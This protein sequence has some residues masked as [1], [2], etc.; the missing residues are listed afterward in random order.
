MNYLSNSAIDTKQLAVSIAKKVTGGT[1]IALNGDLGTGKTTFTQGFA[2][3]LGV[4][5]T[6]ISPTFKLVSEYEG[7]KLWLFHIDAY[8]MNGSQDFLNI[9]GEK[10]LVPLNG[11]T[12]IEWADIISPLLPNNTINI[13]FKRIQNN[14]DGRKIKISGHINDS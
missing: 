5:E 4:T 1:V 12:I 10:Y 2:D 6:V 11:V 3:S 7:D 13:N 14:P 9:G 8:R